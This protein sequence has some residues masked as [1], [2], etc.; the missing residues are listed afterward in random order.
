M[1]VTK[2]DVKAIDFAPIQPLHTNTDLFW[3]DI[4]NVPGDQH[5]KL[6]GYLSTL[7]KGRDI[8][9][10]GTHRGASALALAHNPENTV[11]SFDVIHEYRIPQI[12]NVNYV[13]ENLWSPDI[14]A[15]WEDRLLKSAFI[16]LDIDPHEGT[17]EYD[18]YQ[19]LK[20]KKYQGFLVLDDIWHFQ[21]MRD[22]LWYKIP[23]E[24]K[25]DVTD[26]GHWS[27]TGIVQFTSTAVSIRSAI[28]IGV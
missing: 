22:N 25:M 16:F 7:F 14:L 8:F 17:R 21:A 26:L 27:G 28:L 4:H 6:L 24:D 1:I 9:D 5:Y 13:L 11:Y 10:I 18:F 20:W 12:K 3:N 15:K 2:E 23:N 19:W